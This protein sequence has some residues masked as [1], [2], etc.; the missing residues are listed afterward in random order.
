MITEGDRLLLCTDLDRTLLPNGPQ[1]ESAGAR[2]MFS[3]LVSKDGV[4]LAYVT[5]R[6]RELVQQ[7]MRNYQLPQP[8]FVV[9]DVG[10]TIYEVSGNN[11]QA[12]ESWS[13]HIAQDWDGYQHDDLRALLRDIPDLR[14]QEFRKQGR[15]K[16]SYYVSLNVKNTQLIHEI[17]RRFSEQ[18]IGVSCTWSIDEPASIGLLDILP[19]RASKRLAIEFIAQSQGYAIEEIVFAGD[20]GNDIS[21]MCSEIPSVLVA[22]AT[23]EVRIQAEKD[24]QNQ[25]QSDR[26]YLSKGTYLGMNGNYAAGILEGVAHYRPWYDN[27]LKQ[28]AMS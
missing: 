6:H 15:F 21:V 24:A 20:S 12:L 3:R 10:S 11:W 4:R 9:G 25:G 7:A 14:L 22:N 16:L 2:E 13:A 28:Q 17:E 27:W 5:G 8:D 26:L 19:A 23:E 18:G 1:S